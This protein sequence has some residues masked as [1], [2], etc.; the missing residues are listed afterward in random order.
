MALPPD[1]S[2]AFRCA[3]I[4]LRAKWSQMT[5]REVEGR[6]R[7]ERPKDHQ[8]LREVVDKHLPI[9]VSPTNPS[10]KESEWEVEAR[11]ETQYL[12]DDAPEEAEDALVAYAADYDDQLLQTILEGQPEM[13]SRKEYLVYVAQ[14]GSTNRNVASA[15]GIAEGTVA[16]KT[17]RVR[18]KIEEAREL[19]NFHEETEHFADLDQSDFGL[20]WLIA[21]GVDPDEMPVHA[22]LFGKEMW[23]QVD[24][25]DPGTATIETFAPGYRPGERLDKE[26]AE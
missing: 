7:R 2:A 10:E 3:P 12:P 25:T 18:N 17:G 20:P 22:S 4:A 23:E 26:Q 21:P 13:L 19:L 8:I 16:G 11:A 9:D 5:L 14:L 6:W 24:V 15:F 1:V